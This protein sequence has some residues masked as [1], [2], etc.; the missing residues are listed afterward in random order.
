MNSLAG[1]QTVGGGGLWQGTPIRQVLHVLCATPSGLT[2]LAISLSRDFTP[3]CSVGPLRGPS[4]VEVVCGSAVPGLHNG[5]YCRTP[6]GSW[7]GVAT[8]GTYVIGGDCSLFRDPE[9]V[10]QESPG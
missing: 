1:V 2:L 5:L 8:E 9:R 7:E 6:P 3:G 10:G 4:S